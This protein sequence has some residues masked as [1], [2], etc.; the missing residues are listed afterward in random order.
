MGLRSCDAL[1]IFASEGLLV[2]KLMPD[3]RK[4]SRRAP[5]CQKKDRPFGRSH[6]RLA[7]VQRYF[8]KLRLAPLFRC[9]PLNRL[10]QVDRCSQFPRLA[11]VSRCYHVHRLAPWLQEKRT[12]PKPGFVEQLRRYPSCVSESCFPWRGGRAHKYRA[13][14]K[15]IP[16]MLEFTT[17]WKNGPTLRYT[18][19]PNN[20]VNAHEM[21]K[22]HS[23][24]LSRCSRTLKYRNCGIT[25][26]AIAYVT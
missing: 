25:R 22:A 5:W 8:P 17:S 12:R 9:Y 15:H 2:P 7:R 21:P 6:R 14:I 11:L 13:I 4:C 26:T 3:L 19:L 16:K 24:Q 20:Q 23:N 1:L 18:K 10:A